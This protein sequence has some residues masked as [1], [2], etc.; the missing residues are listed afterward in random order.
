MATRIKL[1]R[2]TTANWTSA[3]PILA[4][5]EPA[6]EQTISGINKLKIG[7]GVTA[8]NDLDYYG[9]SEESATLENQNNGFFKLTVGSEDPIYFAATTV[10]PT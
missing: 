7:D 2:D 6:I 1:R 8:F 5:G 9:L 10:E 3:N 4:D